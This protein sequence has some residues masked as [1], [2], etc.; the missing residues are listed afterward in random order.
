MA[1]AKH[2]NDQAV[3]FELAEEPAIADTVFSELSKA[4]AVQCISDAARIVQFGDSFMQE[5]LDAL[6]LRRV[7]SAEF[8]LG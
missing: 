2:Q 6:D 3:V 7:E 1:D 4:R 8:P 5:L